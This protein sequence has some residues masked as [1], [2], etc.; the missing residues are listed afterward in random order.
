MPSGE[1]RHKDPPLLPVLLPL[2]DDQ[3]LVAYGHHRK[4]LTHKVQLQVRI[5]M[6]KNV[7]NGTQ[8]GREEAAA[9]NEAGVAEGGAILGGGPAGKEGSVFL[10]MELGEVAHEEGG[11]GWVWEEAE[12]GEVLAEEEG[13][14]EWC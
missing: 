7:G 1:C 5:G 9:T 11:G 8:V 4:Q 12:Q 10:V 13:Q 6:A 3:S 14:G 2:D